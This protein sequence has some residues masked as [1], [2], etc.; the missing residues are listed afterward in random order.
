MIIDGIELDEK[1]IPAHVAIIMD[2]NGRWAKQHQRSRNEGHRVGS[3]RVLDIVDAAG[4]LGVN[5]LTIYAFSTEN[6][7][8]PKQE[9]DFLMTLLEDFFKKKLSEAVKK[10]VR[11][12]QIGDMSGLPERTQAV[13]RDT[14]ASSRTNTKL[15]VN[16][17]LN[18]GARDEIVRAVRRIAESV[19]AGTLLP[20]AIDDSV[21]AAHLDTADDPDPDLL[22]RTS[23]EY[24]IS[25][26]LLYQIAYTELWVTQT[27]WPDFSPKEFFQAIADY[28]SRERRFGG[29]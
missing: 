5:I 20:D 19:K 14:E 25:N 23:G 17:A 15:K 2:G 24:R 29:I 12:T 16:V 22:I 10:G 7:K 6:W 4:R 21:I 18:Y 1:R 8:R 28:Q 13:I 9:V 3:E 26:F 11:I 27:L